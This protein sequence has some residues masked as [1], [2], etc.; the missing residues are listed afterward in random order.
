M[1]IRQK[2][3]VLSGIIGVIMAVVSCI[4]YY[5]AYTNLE[6]SVRQEI[7]ATVEVQ[8]QSMDGWLKEKASPAISAA[9]LMSEL[10][11]H[12]E[13]TTMKETMRLAVSD[14]EIMGLTNGNEDGLFLSGT[15]DNTGK[16]DPRTRSWYKDAKAAG[17]LIFTNAYKDAL[18]GKLVISAAAPYKDK[19]GNFRGAICDDISIDTLQQR[20]GEI[21]YRGQGKGMIIENGGTIL[22]S[23]QDGETMQT[24]DSNEGLKEHFQ[25][26]LQKKNGYF[27]TKKEGETKVFAYTTIESTGWILGV[28]VPE[29][30]VFAAVTKLKITYAVLTILGILLIVFA[31]LKFSSRITSTVIRIKNHA[32][33]LAKGNLRV[34]DLAVESS[35]ELGTLSAAFNTM[36]GNIRE[37][38]RK[39]ATTAEQVAASS[40]ELTAGAQQSAEAANHV[41]GTVSQVSDGMADQL[42]SVDHAKKDVDIV[43]TDI[44]QVADKTKKITE[45]SAQTA[46]A[47]QQ[48]EQLMTGA[49]AKMGHIESSVSE[50][51][52]VV[53]K[54]GENSKQIGQIVDAISA[55]A[56]QTNLLAL[57]AAIEA[58]RAGEHGRG[59]AVVAEEVRKL[60]AESQQSAEEIKERIGVI[61]RDTEQAVSS[62]QNGTNEVQQGA[63]AIRD[64]GT[65]FASIMGMVNEIKDQ[66]DD[67]NTA[68]TAVT[69]GANRIVA[70]VDSIDEV[71]RATSEHTQSI[72]AATQEQSASTEEIASASQ[73]LAQMAMD[74]QEATGKFKI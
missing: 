42:E 64:V 28:S 3:F 39:M 61:Q 33:E 45:N 9:N 58:A 31:S 6:E 22:A 14:K 21:K 50:S 51:A 66:M 13:L 4:G 24:V 17:K 55:I 1:G 26:M 15:E 62:M 7:L 43:F 11:S 27:L 56:D 54:L 69:D 36:S 25:Q 65:Q 47:A 72:S 10:D 63:A 41:A 34:D 73:A 2:F 40:E 44:S 20:V 32:D 57:N 53:Q 49:M 23:T 71:S 38:I 19:A 30:F 8:G 52:E 60:A 46:Q 37:L 48:G 12:P 70:A 18:T 16:V 5:T 29:T 35:D 67:I 74:L 68:V 59:F